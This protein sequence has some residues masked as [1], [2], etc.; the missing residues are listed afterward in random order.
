MK[1]TKPTI[2][3]LLSGT[4]LLASCS[5]MTMIQSYPTNAKLYL[6]G[7]PVGT[8][9][10]S[11]TDTKIV[12]SRTEV[13]IVKDGYEPLVTS[14]TRDE[15]VDVGAIIGGLFVWVPFLWTMKYQP[16]HNYELVP[17]TGDMQQMEQDRQSIS[18]LKSKTEIL[19]DLKQ[20]LDEKVLTQEEYAKEKKK[21]LD[22]VEK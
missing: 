16:T 14:I 18:N 8:T 11:L 19:R 5:S 12:G 15:T 1:K 10:Y 21:V 20:L 7:Q 9:P 13:K 2:S 3:L 22:D 17:Y 6:N 4:I